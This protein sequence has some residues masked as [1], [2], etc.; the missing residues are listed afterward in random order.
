[1]YV[2]Y[3]HLVCLRPFGVFCGHLASVPELFEQ[4]V[5]MVQ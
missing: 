3:G 4:D 1:M 5:K 2:L